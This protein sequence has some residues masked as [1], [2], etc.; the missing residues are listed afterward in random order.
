MS[1]ETP[2]GLDEPLL[3]ARQGP[4]LDGDG[5]GESAQKIAQV[6]GKIASHGDSAEVR[7]AYGAIPPRMA[8][9]TERTVP[10]VKS[11]T[12][13]ETNYRQAM[14][15]ADEL[16]MRPLVAHCHLGFGKLYGRVDKW[17]QAREHLAT[18]TAMYHAMAMRSWQEQAEAALGRC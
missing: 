6:L 17:Q 9:S 3:Q 4:A 18:A 2:A 11:F 13:P 8:A 15:L 5:Q 1:H 14:A 10:S 7:N 12:V 16:G